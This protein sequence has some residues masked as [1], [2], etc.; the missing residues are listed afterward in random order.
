MGPVQP[1]VIF[2]ILFWS[3]V[4]GAGIYAV[5]RFLRILE[6]RAGTEA[7]LAALRE[8]VVILEDSVEDVRGLVERI[9]ASQEF[10]TK[11]LSGRSSRD[12]P[13]T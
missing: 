6:H 13:V 12:E 1:F 5:R 2:V 7:E 4:V 3:I 8:R 10:T 11:L 9:D